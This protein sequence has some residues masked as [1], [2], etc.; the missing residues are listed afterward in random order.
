MMIKLVCIQL[1]DILPSLLLPKIIND[2]MFFSFLYAH[3]FCYYVTST[4]TVES[5]SRGQGSGTAIH[6]KWTEIHFI[7][8]IKIKN[9]KL[10]FTAMQSTI[11]WHTAALGWTIIL[12]AAS[13][14]NTFLVVETREWMNFYVC[15]IMLVNQMY[16]SV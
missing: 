4:Q 9:W 14:C 11:C 12:N 13:E 6:K 8:D 1:R 5:S 10:S 15:A 7:M 16:C 3:N 2:M